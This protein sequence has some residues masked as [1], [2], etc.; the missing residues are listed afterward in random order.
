MNDGTTP[1]FDLDFLI[2]EFN[3]FDD[4]ALARNE[5]WLKK[6]KAKAEKEGEDTDPLVAID[7]LI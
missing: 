6:N 2:R 5:D 7:N 1:K 4:E 3:L